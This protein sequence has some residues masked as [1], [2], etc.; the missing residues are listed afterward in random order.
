MNFQKFDILL[1]ELSNKKVLITTH[2]Q[3]DLDGFTSCVLLK[4]FLETYSDNIQVRLFFSRFSQF[5]FDFLSR[6]EKIFPNISSPLENRE[7]YFDTEFIII[8]DTNNLDQVVFPESIIKT[9]NKIPFIFIDHHFDLN[10]DITHNVKANNIIIDSITSTA[11]I[12][13]KIFIHYE[14]QVPTRFRYLLLAAI[15]TDTGGFKNANND[16]FNHLSNI[17]N[18]NLKF[19]DFLMLIEKKNDF[20]KKVAI[21]K[22]LQRVKIK[23][24]NNWLIGLSYVGSYTSSVAS[25]L[26][27][28]GFDVSIVYSKEPTSFRITTRAKKEICLKTGL[29]LGKILSEIKEG[30][31]GGHDGAASLNG[32]NSFESALNLILEKI[33][34]TLNNI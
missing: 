22:G 26:L 28:I 1:S 9:K 14:I 13:F 24:I 20:A 16:T 34:K 19:Q 4:Y 2:D 17:L 27:Q 32:E 15:Y 30:S 33:K 18:S 12:L 7:D 21:I 6:L 8:L 5:T 3:V 25:A 29:H 10:H 31:G 11:E 23:K